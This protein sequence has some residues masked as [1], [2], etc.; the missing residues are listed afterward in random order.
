MQAMVA[1]LDP[2]WTN[3][4]YKTSGEKEESLNINCMVEDIEELVLI[5]LGVIIVEAYSYFLMMHIKY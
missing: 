3:Q 5:C 4:P 2:I 1:S